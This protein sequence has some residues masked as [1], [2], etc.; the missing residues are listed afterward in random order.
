M[1]R[2]RK[3]LGGYLIWPRRAAQPRRKSGSSQL[4]FANRPF[5]ILMSLMKAKAEKETV[6]FLGERRLDV[7]ELSCQI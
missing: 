5:H 4:E 7:G 6:H 1:P 3:G 2:R